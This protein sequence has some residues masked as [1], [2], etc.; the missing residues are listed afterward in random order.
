M[1]FTVAS[2]PLVVM[3]TQTVVSER[4][5]SEV[6]V[7]VVAVLSAR[8]R[9]KKSL[10]KLNSRAAAKRSTKASVMKREKFMRKCG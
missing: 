3:V 4:L 5:D 6:R 8:L 1:V 7:V 10:A 9:W 2:P